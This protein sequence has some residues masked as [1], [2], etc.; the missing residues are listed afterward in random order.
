MRTA[1]TTAQARVRGITEAS[2]KWQVGKGTMQRVERGVYLDG[3]E[4]ANAVERALAQVVAVGGV[5]AGSLAG[6]LHGLDSV[7]IRRPFVAVPATHPTKRDDVMRRCYFVGDVG[8]ARGIACTTGMQTLIELAS[9]LDDITWEQAL[10]S[11]LRKR[12]FVATELED[13][14]EVLGASRVPGTARIRRVLKLRPPGAPP[15]E[16]LLETLM[17]QLIRIETNLPAPTRQVVVNNRHDQFIARVDLGWPDVGLFLELDGQ[18][19]KDQPVYDA[20][21]ETAVVATTGWLPGR[22]TWYEET[23]IPKPTARRV[24]ELYAQA[25]LHRNSRL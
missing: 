16:S 19:H 25:H 24:E 9:S 8:E 21:R 13:R 10:E 6:V 12:L 23:R 17:V 4:P 18:Q 20:R 11:A 3:T 14:L 7:H 5:A 2:L 1:F 15:T 22:F